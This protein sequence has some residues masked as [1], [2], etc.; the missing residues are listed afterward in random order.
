MLTSEVL[1]ALLELHRQVVAI[2]PEDAELDLVV[3]GEACRL[4]E[5]RLKQAKVTFRNIPYDVRAR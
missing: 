1:A 2:A 3:Y 5:E 4:G